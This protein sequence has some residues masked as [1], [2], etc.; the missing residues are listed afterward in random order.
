MIGHYLSVAETSFCCPISLYSNPK[1]AFHGTRLMHSQQGKSN[2]P[3]LFELLKIDTCPP[4]KYKDFNQS[5]TWYCA[6]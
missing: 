3:Y 6:S 4:K 2:S 5:V 1:F